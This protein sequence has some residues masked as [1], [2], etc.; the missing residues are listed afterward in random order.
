[1]KRMLLVGLATA[2]LVGCSDRPTVTEPDAD[3]APS[4][5]VSDGAN[6]GNPNFFFL[7]PLVPHARA[8]GAF[9]PNLMPVVEICE[10]NDAAEPACVDGPPV[11]RFESVDVNARR[12]FYRVKWHTR[13]AGLRIGQIYRIRVLVGTVELG[14]RDV[15]PVRRW[16][17]LLFRRYRQVYNFVPVRTIP[18]KFRIEDGALC[19]EAATDCGEGTLTSEGGIVTTASQ[20]AGVEAFPGSIAEGEEV[21]VIVEKVAQPCL[22][23][24]L[25]QFDDCYRFRTEPPLPDGFQEVVT[26]GVC[27][28]PAG[29]SEEQQ[30]RVLLHRVEEPFGPDSPVFPLANVSAGF[31]ECPTVQASENANWLFN[32][33][34]V[35]ARSLLDVLAP[36]AHA[37]HKGLGG[38]TIRF[39]R[40]GWALPAE[41]TE[42]SGNGQIGTAGQP[43]PHDLVVLLTDSAGAPVANATITFTVKEG[44]GSVSPGVVVTGPDGLAS[45]QWTLG[46][47]GL[48]NVLSASARGVVGSPVDFSAIGCPAPV[49]GNLR[50][51]S[52]TAGR[53]DAG[54]RAQSEN[55]ALPQANVVVCL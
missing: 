3:L 4:L 25:P 13:R 2:L 19:D 38:S 14:Y 8:N 29:L 24:D 1:M 16:L 35:G 44:D 48:N 33:A 54:T 5:A 47:N 51:L 12:E 36:Q 45:V 6:G 7:P 9:N 52:D 21:T 39:S 53:P 46:V 49:H 55:T 40:I 10:L 11:E 20:Q 26:V 22:P 28:D 30:A 23:T 27:L 37:I 17:P 34:S 15:R 41:M 32:L 43:L 31:V 42:Q 18:I 50:A